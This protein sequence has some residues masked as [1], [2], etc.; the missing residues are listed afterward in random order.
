[1]SVD[2]L[3]EL[4]ADPSRYGLNTYGIELAEEVRALRAERDAL[5]A[6]AQRDIESWWAVGCHC[7][8]QPDGSRTHKA[9]C[10][11]IQIDQLRAQVENQ[12]KIITDFSGQLASAREAL[13]K[14]PHA[15]DCHARPDVG[16]IYGPC[17]CY[18]AAE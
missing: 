18:K 6:Q 9:I 1:M 17:H 16:P 13:E 10:P 3:N 11:L 14:A 7:G 5:K 12:V 4:I 15:E 8:I 2:N